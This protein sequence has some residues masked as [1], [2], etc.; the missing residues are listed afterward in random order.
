VIVDW[1]LYEPHREMELQCRLFELENV[2]DRHIALC[3]DAVDPTSLHRYRTYPLDAFPMEDLRGLWQ[4]FGSETSFV[5]GKI[6][7]IPRRSIVEGFS[8]TKP[9]VLKAPKLVY[10]VHYRHERSVFSSI[11][12][13]KKHFNK[14]MIASLEKRRSYEAIDDGGWVLDWFGGEVQLQ[15]LLSEHEEPAIRD[16]RKAIAEKYPREHISPLGELLIPHDGDTPRWHIMGHAPN[17]WDLE[18]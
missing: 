10:S 4:E 13:K 9:A 1:F 5:M 7:E 3:P 14:G 18:W 15:K 2:V 6:S 11:I 8:F 12:G 17:S 16:A